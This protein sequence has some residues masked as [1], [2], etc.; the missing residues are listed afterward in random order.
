MSTAIFRREDVS[1]RGGEIWKYHGTRSGAEPL[2]VT[3]MINNISPFKDKKLSETED[4]P[5]TS[6]IL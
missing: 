2:L 4:D 5:I 6:Q 1:L 3:G